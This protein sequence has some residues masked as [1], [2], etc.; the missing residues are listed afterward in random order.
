MSDTHTGTDRA[1]DSSAGERPNGEHS[2]GSTDVTHSKAPPGPDGLPVVGNA[3]QLFRD[4]TG[5]DTLLR[6]Y[7]DVVRYSIFSQEFTSLFHP[8]HIERVLVG[9]P[10]RF[11][12]YAFEELS[13]EFAPD[14]LLMS[15]GE[16]WR[17]QRELI[18]PAFSPARIA[19][20]ADEI[21]DR[22]ATM[23]EGWDDGEV[24]SAND[25]FSE[26]TLEVLTTTL[27]DL[28]FTDRR[29]TVAAAAASLNEIADVRNPSAF[30][31]AWVPTPSRRR[32]RRR[33]NRF[34]SL[35]ADLL[36]ERRATEDAANDLLSTLVAATD[37]EADTA[38][39][40]A[41]ELRDQLITF[42]FAGHETTALALTY[43]CWL[44][45]RHEDAQKRLAAELE[46]VC[47]DREPT[48]ADLPALEY[49]ER[50]IREGLRLY[51]PAFLLL[52]QT[53]EPVVFEG[54]R[55]P[56]GSVVT[57]PQFSLH[58]DERFWDEPE[59]FR[60]D[61]FLEAAERPEYAYFP[62][63]GGPRHCVGMRFAMLELQLT[64]ATI[65]RRIRFDAL[66]SEL[67]LQLA[68]TMKPAE[69][70]SLLVQKRDG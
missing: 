18:Q 57:L 28:E 24:V 50:V 65:A 19:A 26:L 25:A 52:R 40:S 42:L 51:P 64:L 7:G 35:I 14:G 48:M 70:V 47:G 63:G 21:V 11:E 56:E 60:P 29:E 8:D 36:E 66:D 30:L 20:F 23:V 45:G 1:D 12:Q 44:L 68:A 31:P 32:Y 34:D 37:E 59:A 69:P 15:T 6:P 43:T 17:R 67:P 49:T 22:T 3:H 39:L 13:V 16:Q 54:Y 27:F 10:E 61:R 46:S 55:L 9:E 33:M 4:P 2:D 41:D 58:R 62:F 53:R 38:T 5:F